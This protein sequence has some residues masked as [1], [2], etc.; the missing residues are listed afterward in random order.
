MDNLDITTSYR[1]SSPNKCPACN[2]EFKSFG[3]RQ[4]HL[5]TE[6]FQHGD[7]AWLRKN[8]PAEYKQEIQPIKP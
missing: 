1:P 3:A 7:L 2:R 8:T 4:R 5:V 6:H